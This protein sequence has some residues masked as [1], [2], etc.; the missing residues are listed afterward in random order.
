MKPTR[1]TSATVLLLSVGLLGQQE[2]VLANQE[3]LTPESAAQISR[4]LIPS[5]SQEF[6]QRGREQFEREIQ[7]LYRG[8]DALTENLL[9]INVNPEVDI[10][11]EQ[12]KPG[13]FPTPSND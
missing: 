5:S 13:D 11:Q 12:I 6:F 2:S 9:T 4:D 3:S 1:V 8:Q 10:Q 7:R